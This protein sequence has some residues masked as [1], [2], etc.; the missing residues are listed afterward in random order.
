VQ[1]FEALKSIY[2]HGRRYREN[3]VPVVI[4]RLTVLLGNTI[5]E[6]WFSIVAKSIEVIT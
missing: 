1:D 2:S 4:T 6:I 3:P 5:P